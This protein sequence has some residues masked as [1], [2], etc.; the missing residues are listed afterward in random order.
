MPT[1]VLAA[2][3]IPNQFYGDMSFSGGIAAPDGVLIEAKINEQVVA[4]TWTKNGKYGY[5]PN[6]FFVTDPDNNRK[7][8]EINFFVNGLDTEQTSIF[9]NGVSEEL[10][11]SLSNVEAGT[12]EKTESDVIAS[13]IV[14]IIPENPTVIKMGD[15]LSVFLESS[16][17]TNALVEKIEKLGTDFFTGATAI[18]SGK[19]LLNGYEIKISG[20]N[21]DISVTMKYDDTG[22][23]EDS[24]APY[25]FD[26][27]SWV[28]IEPFI[29]DKSANTITFN[30]SSA[31][32]PYVIFGSPVSTGGTPASSSG[33]G[34]PI[35]SDTVAPLISDVNFE[36]TR[37]IATITWQTNENSI[38]WII[39]GETTDYGKEIKTTTYSTSHSIT[40]INLTPDVAYHFQ[41]KSK[42]ST[43]NIG[44]S[45]DR[46]FTTLAARIAGDTNDDGKVD[47]YDFAL[48][49]SAWGK[50][51]INN[52]DLN[53]D[54][55]IDKYDFA[56]LMA[57]WTK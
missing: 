27:T 14:V 5:N 25:K 29:I 16:N 1:L 51:G 53:G 56:L 34:T 11:F 13:T 21:I 23:D 52:S 19:N 55:K 47:K 30:I 28:P 24:I 7:D 39:Y 15:K 49:M 45:T 26:G 57:N 43:G 10:V 44:S 12:I 2:P 9:E 18:L 35:S 22:I 20:E 50:T 37:T 48:M 33:G 3:G 41:I 32:T 4:S 54:N 38:S 6:L 8:K 46:S 40:L 17:N 42:D 31:D 36:V